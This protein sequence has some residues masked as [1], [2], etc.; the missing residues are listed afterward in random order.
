MKHET[1]SFRD[2]GDKLLEEIEK[3]KKES[4]KSCVSIYKH[5]CRNYGFSEDNLTVTANPNGIML[6]FSGIPTAS[7]SQ[8]RYKLECW[9]IYMLNSIRLYVAMRRILKDFSLEGRLPTTV[10]S[11]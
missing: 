6:I 2:M 7:S 9:H 8:F 11:I 5:I 1:L 10:P 4:F 3:T